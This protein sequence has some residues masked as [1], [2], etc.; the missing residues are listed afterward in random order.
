MR[1]LR[2]QYEHFEPTGLKPS[3]KPVAPQ[4][5]GLPKSSVNVTRTVC[6]SSVGEL[7]T[8]ETAAKQSLSTFHEMWTDDT[9]I[10]VAD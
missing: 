8:G 9:I 7:P 6:H 3:L 1:R 2:I 5:T 10:R 4:A